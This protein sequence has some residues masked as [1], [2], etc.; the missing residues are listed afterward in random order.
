MGKLV[1]CISRDGTL[2]AMA[3]DTTDIVREAA[4]IHHTTNVC[5]AALGRLLTAASFM[6]HMLKEENGSVTLRV[7]GG[8]EA[9]SVIAVSDSRGNVRGYI[10]NSTVELPL[11]A[12]G[13]LDVGKAVGKDGALTVMK[14]FGA[15]DPYIG[16]TPL[17]SGEIAEDITA[18][19]AVSEQTPTVC[20]LGV[21]TVPVQR[22]IITAGGLLIQLLPTADESVIAKVEECVKGIKPVTAM[23]TDGLSP[24]EICRTALPA[25]EMECLGEYETAYRCACSREKVEQALLSTG[26]AGLLEMAKDPM[27]EVTCHFCDKVYTF[28]SDEIKGLLKKA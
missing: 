23:L 18:Y 28:S 1:R 9:G 2:L 10:E 16:Q 27:T 5:S 7:N 25:F 19:Y 3:A 17:V 26:K 11:K 24:F 21:L 8:G 6:G 14:D 20:A 13:K 12:P 15:G 22:Q 4:A